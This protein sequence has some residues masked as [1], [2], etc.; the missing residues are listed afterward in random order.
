MIPEI[1]RRKTSNVFCD[2]FCEEGYFN[3]TDQARKILE[4]SQKIMV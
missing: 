1:G 3:K 2:V 4:S